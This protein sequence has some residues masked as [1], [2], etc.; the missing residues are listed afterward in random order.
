[1]LQPYHFLN[2]LISTAIQFHVLTIFLLARVVATL[3]DYPFFFADVELSRELAVVF[4]DNALNWIVEAITDVVCAFRDFLRLATW[5]VSNQRLAIWAEV[6][7]RYFCVETAILEGRVVPS[8]FFKFKL[9]K[10]IVSARY[11]LAAVPLCY[12]PALLDNSVNV[13]S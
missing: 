3:L 8:L 1:M 5:V 10:E 6:I 7:G 11:Q 12:I 13:N 4:A 9:V 2:D